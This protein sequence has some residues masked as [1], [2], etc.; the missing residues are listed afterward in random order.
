ML[1]QGNSRIIKILELAISSATLSVANRYVLKSFGFNWPFALLSVQG[2]ILF[3]F[4]EVKCRLGKFERVDKIQEEYLMT[5]AFYLLISYG[6]S[7]YA[8][9]LLDFQS[10]I[11]LGYMSIPIAF[12]AALIKSKIQNKFIVFLFA[13]ATLAGIAV[14][15]FGG[16]TMNI[17]GIIAALIS[18]A[19]FGVSLINSSLNIVRF[20]VSGE[21][22]LHGISQYMAWGGVAFCAAFECTDKHVFWRHNFSV[23]EVIG[24]IVSCA[25]FVITLLT[26]F[27]QVSISPGSTNIAISAGSVFLY[28]ITLFLNETKNTFL[29]IVGAIVVLICSSLY[30][31]VGL[32]DKVEEKAGSELKDQETLINSDETI[33]E[34]NE[35]HTNEEE[36]EP[37]NIVI[38]EEVTKKLEDVKENEQ[39]VAKPATVSPEGSNK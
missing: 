11:V 22:Y 38:A 39:E 21:Q 13:G 8:H 14:F 25:L 32:S 35:T 5:S 19:G 10:C 36:K 27:S 33:D 17:P 30:T 16:S 20:E 26:Y 4:L 9:K 7:Y 15:I 18:G 31:L 23:K 12:V 1:N 2:I 24:I 3:A 6:F 29:K 34:I 28:L 37:Q